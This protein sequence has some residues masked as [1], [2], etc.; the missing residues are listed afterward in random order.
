MRSHPLMA[1][2][3]ELSVYISSSPAVVRRWSSAHLNSLCMLK[4]TTKD[5]L[6]YELMVPLVPSNLTMLSGRSGKV[7]HNTKCSMVR[8]SSRSGE[9]IVASVHDKVQNALRIQSEVHS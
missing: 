7:C 5:E 4:P 1:P 2:Q 6:R 8:A 9:N 3:S